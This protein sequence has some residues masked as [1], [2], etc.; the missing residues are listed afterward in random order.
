MKKSEILSRYT[1]IKLDEYSV[2]IQNSHFHFAYTI[3]DS[4]VKDEYKGKYKYF[5][6]LQCGFIEDTQE[7][8]QLE[9]WL[10]EI[11]DKILKK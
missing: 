10:I 8:K 2:F 4:V 9:N 1:I 3:A 7:Y 6:G 11:V 5:G